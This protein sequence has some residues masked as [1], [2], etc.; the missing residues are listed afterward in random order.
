MCLIEDRDAVIGE[1]IF[2]TLIFTLPALWS[3][4]F[5]NKITFETVVTFTLTPVSDFFSAH[6]LKH[7]LAVWNALGVTT[8]TKHSVGKYFF[9]F[10]YVL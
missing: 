3:L 1:T 8:K 5:V 4:F 2:N 10:F 6:L 9:N 7:M